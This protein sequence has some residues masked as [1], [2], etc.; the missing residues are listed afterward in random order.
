MTGIELELISDIDM[1]LFIEKAMKGGI[2]DITKRHRKVNNKYMQSYDINKP[3][4]FI[5]YLD[6]H[7]LFG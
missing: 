5:S 7:N 1:P 6:V 2:S 3:S 4:K